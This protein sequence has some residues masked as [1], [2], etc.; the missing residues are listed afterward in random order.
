M[1]PR[2]SHEAYIPEKMKIEIIVTHLS[3]NLQAKYLFPHP[4]TG[5]V[6][7]GIFLT[8]KTF[9]DKIAVSKLVSEES[10]ELANHIYASRITL[11]VL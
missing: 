4:L 1:V 3:L 10:N 5:L 9:G 7:S 2:S 6:S 8:C 11:Q